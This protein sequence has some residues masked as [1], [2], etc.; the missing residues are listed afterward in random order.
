M[1]HL[2]GALIHKLASQHSRQK[3]PNTTQC[4]HPMHPIYPH[5][6]PPTLT[7]SPTH[8]H[9]NAVQAADLLIARFRRLSKEDPDSVKR[10]RI[11]VPLSS[12]PRG[13]L[14]R[15]ISSWA[16]TA[17]DLLSSPRRSGEA[18]EGG[19]GD[20]SKQWW[21]V[22][23]NSRSLLNL[24]EQAESHTQVCSHPLWVHVSVMGGSV[25]EDW[26]G[27]REQ[28]EEVLVRTGADGCGLACVPISVQAPVF[29][30]CWGVTPGGGR[31]REPM[32]D[33][34]ETRSIC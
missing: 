14:E 8:L 7:P 2:E 32:D 11:T 1:I 26:C 21:G 12:S 19:E 33:E 5:D 15:S 13:Q 9:P 30:V 18:S 27:G 4:P 28:A 25:L 16:L 23:R 10:P 29:C 6:L 24:G 20:A 22:R 17:P 31:G 34:G 3:A